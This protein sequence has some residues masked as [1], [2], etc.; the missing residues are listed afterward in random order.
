M[1]EHQSKN[2]ILLSVGEVREIDL[3]KVG[4]IYM[5]VFRVVS[6]FLALG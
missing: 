5:S 6:S 4:M 3:K 2:V 1:L